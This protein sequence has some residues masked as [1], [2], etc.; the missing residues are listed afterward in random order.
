MTNRKRNI[1][2]KKK[3]LKPFGGNFQKC[4]I[5]VFRAR[6]KTYKKWDRGWYDHEYTEVEIKIKGQWYYKTKNTHYPLRR[7]KPYYMRKRIRFDRYIEATI[8]HHVRLYGLPVDVE[9]QTIK[10][11]P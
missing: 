6:T 9:I 10:I 1:E 3:L 8:S 4:E 2:L 7:I 5:E 11:L